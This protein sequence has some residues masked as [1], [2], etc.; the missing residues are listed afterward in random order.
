MPGRWMQQTRMLALP[1]QPSA[2]HALHRDILRQNLH[3]ASPV[4]RITRIPPTLT[5]QQ[6]ARMI[7]AILLFRQRNNSMLPPSLKR[8]ADA[9]CEVRNELEEDVSRRSA[10]QEVRGISPVA[11]SA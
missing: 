9:F 7:T 5:S 10:S 6:H 2:V 4:P 1:M 8:R 3:R 11:C